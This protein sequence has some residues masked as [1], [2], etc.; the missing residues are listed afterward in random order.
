MRLFFDNLGEKK[1]KINVFRA[2]PLKLYGMHYATA[3]VAGPLFR[4]VFILDIVF[5]FF[6]YINIYYY[7][8]YNIIIF[9][10]FI[11]IILLLLLLL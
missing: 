6:F 4:R 11:F 9:I 2:E 3:L 8:Y 7:Y 1:K 5:F 10:I